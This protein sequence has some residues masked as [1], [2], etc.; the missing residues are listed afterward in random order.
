MFH[1]IKQIYIQ[2]KEL[3]IQNLLNGWRNWMLSHDGRWILLTLKKKTNWI[4]FIFIVCKYLLKGLVKVVYF[5]HLIVVSVCS[6]HPLVSIGVGSRSPNRYQ[7]P[8]GCGWSSP[9]YKMVK[10]SLPSVYHSFHIC[11]FHQSLV[12]VLQVQR[13]DCVR[14]TDTPY[15]FLTNWRFVAALHCQM[16]AFFDNKV[17]LS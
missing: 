6:H 7:N 11:G 1:K 14:F 8:C 3:F 4:F 10:Y 17:F 5:D 13:A 9:V 2:G 15:F 12:W 16:I